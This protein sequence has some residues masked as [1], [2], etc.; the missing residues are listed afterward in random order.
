MRDALAEVKEAILTRYLDTSSVAAKTRMWRLLHLSDRLHLWREDKLV[1]VTSVAP[2]KRQA[3]DTKDVKPRP[4]LREREKVCSCGAKF[5]ARSNNAVYCGACKR[6]RQRV[7]SHKYYAANKEMERAKFR[8]R[9]AAKRG[10]AYKPQSVCSSAAALKK[11]KV[12]ES[13]ESNPGRVGA[14]DQPAR[15]AKSGQLPASVQPL[16]TSSSSRAVDANGLAGAKPAALTHQA[17][18]ASV[19]SMLEAVARR[20]TEG[21]AVLRQAARLLTLGI[22]T[23]ETFTDLTTT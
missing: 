17:T 11:L 2:Q 21:A 15:A 14:A 12:K 1:A 20:Y 6:E 10:A 3:A 16:V 23:A 19:V 8:A 9:Y 13:R 4:G 7:W 5:Q 18:T 22:E